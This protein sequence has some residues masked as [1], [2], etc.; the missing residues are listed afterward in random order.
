MI[1]RFECPKCSEEI[2][3][4]VDIG[5]HLVEWGEECENEKCGYKFTKE[6]VL[7]I[8]DE[9]LTDCFSG[10]VDYI[11]DTMKDG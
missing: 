7:K 4:E 5:E 9:A 8:Y 10:M 11:H 6:E 1:H 3:A 2:T